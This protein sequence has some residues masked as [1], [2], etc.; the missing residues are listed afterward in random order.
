MTNIVQWFQQLNFDSLIELVI[1]VAAALMCI[2]FHECAHG[3]VAYWLGDPTAKRMGR[4]T[5]NPIKHID[6]VGLVMMA[7]AHVGWAKPVPVDMRNFKHPKWGMA[8]TAAAGP[9]CNIL[10][11]AVMMIPFGILNVCYQVEGG[12]VLYDCALFFNYAAVLSCGLALFNLIPISP[13]DGSKVLLTVLPDK[14]YAK[15]MHYER[16]GM[17]VLIA[18]VLLEPY[19]FGGVSVL[20]KAIDG[21]WNGLWA[22]AKYPVKGVLSLI[23]PTLNIIY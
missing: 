14:A 5:L 15:A 1:M 7:V 19:L 6:I 12:K 4:L 11:A 8:L 3:L 23:Y 16:Y 9:L 20:D 21:L 10:L 22:I 2:I 18:L 17:F 13:L